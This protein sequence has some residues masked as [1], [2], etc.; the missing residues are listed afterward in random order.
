MIRS[1]RRRAAH[2]LI[3]GL[4]RRC[5]SPKSDRVLAAEAACWLI[6]GDR[7]LARIMWEARR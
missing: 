3:L 5:A 2:R 6:Y 4:H 1:L 7:H